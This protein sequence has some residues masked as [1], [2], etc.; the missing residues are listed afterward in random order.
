VLATWYLCGSPYGVD[1]LSLETYGAQNFMDTFYGDMLAHP[2][3]DEATGELMWF[4]YGPDLPYLRYGVIGADGRQ[5]H[6]AHI[7]VPGPWLPHDMAITANYSIL[8]DLP[9][10]Q[11]QEARRAGKYRI[12][13]D[14]S[15]VSRFAVIPRHVSPED[16]RWFEARPCYIYHV[17][18][19]WEPATRSSWTCAG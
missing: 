13:Y 9:L 19:S 8:M 15:L 5:S 16:V 12:Y 2:K 7:D 6:L 18:N 14:K 1:P 17:V 3:V 4:D 11:D 10:V